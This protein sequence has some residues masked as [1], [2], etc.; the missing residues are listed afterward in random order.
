[1][2]DPKLEEA[3]DRYNAACENFQKPMTWWGYVKH[4][5]FGALGR[6]FLG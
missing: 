1:M 3:M 6:I 4:F 2:D 5:L